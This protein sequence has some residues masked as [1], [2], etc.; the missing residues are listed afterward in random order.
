MNGSHYTYFS[1]RQPVDL[2][3]G[4]SSPEAE[5]ATGATFDELPSRLKEVLGLM[6]TC[7]T[8]KI[9]AAC[10][11]NLD[12]DSTLDIR[13]VSTGMLP[14]QDIHGDDAEPGRPFHL[15]DDRDD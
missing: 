1:G 13:V 5:R 2:R 8:C 14:L 11:T 6:G 9:T 3:R 4:T 15:V 12:E 10:A 7:P